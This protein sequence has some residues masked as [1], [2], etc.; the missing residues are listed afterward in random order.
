MVPLPASLAIVRC[1]PDCLANPYVLESPARAF[2]GRLGGKKWLPR[3]LQDFRCHTDTVVDN[4]Q[5]D[6]VAGRKTSRGLT[7][8]ET[9]IRGFYQIFPPLG[10][11]SRALSTRLRSALPNS[12]GSI[13]TCH[14][15]GAITDVTVMVSP[16][17]R[18]NISTMLPT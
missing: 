7:G 16:I 11:P 14:K 9:R 4:G 15:S 6:I 1:P 5:P 10:M 3:A 13:C 12:P 2:A 17:V 18:C 8:A